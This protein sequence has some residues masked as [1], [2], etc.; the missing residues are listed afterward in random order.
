MIIKFTN[1][2]HIKN[3]ITIG[4]F[5]KSLREHFEFEEFPQIENSLMTT[6]KQFS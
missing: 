5:L 2:I 1:L 4:K 6:Q 3:L